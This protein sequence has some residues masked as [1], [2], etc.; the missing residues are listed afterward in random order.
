MKLLRSVAIS[1]GLVAGQ[2]EAVDLSSYVGYTI[3]HSDTVTAKSTTTD[4]EPKIPDFKAM[5]D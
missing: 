2:A 4:T 1:A 5:I 3:V